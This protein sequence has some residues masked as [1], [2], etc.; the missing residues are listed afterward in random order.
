MEQGSQ[1]EKLELFK[2]QVSAFNYILEMHAWFPLGQ[3]TVEKAESS[4][5]I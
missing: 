5:N 3:A 4:F 1:N 2:S